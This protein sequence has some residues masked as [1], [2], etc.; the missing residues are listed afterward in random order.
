M[1]PA[2][3]SGGPDPSPQWLRLGGEILAILLPEAGATLG[4]EL[5]FGT[6]SI[7]RPLSQLPLPDR[8]SLLLARDLGDGDLFLRQGEAAFQKLGP[9]QSA[10]HL[11]PLLAAPRLLALLA[12]KAA[13]PLRAAS[14]PA[15]ARDLIA[16]VAQLA[17]PAPEATRPV[18]LLGQGRALWRLEAGGWLLTPQGLLR[19]PDPEGG[20]SPLPA[21]AAGALL[22]RSEGPP[23]RLPPAPP[24]PPTL[25]EIAR[26]EAGS[27]RG[28]LQQSLM[29]LRRHTQEP[30]C[31]DTIRDAQ[32]LAMA[33]TR[34]AA[35]PANAV[36]AAVDRALS[37]HA[38]GVFLI[39]WLHDPLRLTR[40][41]TLR[42]PFGGTLL[43]A[44][45][46]FRV[47]RPD[48][49]KR[50]EQAPFGG[51]DPRPG[52]VVH[53]PSAGPGP[54]A[55]WRVELALGSGEAI[56]LVA[57]P[58]LI[59]PAQ[60]REAVLRGVSPLDVG[61]DLLDR[62]LTPAAERLHRAASAEA[63][64]IDVVHIGTPVA[65]P[66][67]SLV[68]PLYRNLRF[69]KHQLAAFARDPA[70]RGCEIIYVLDSPEQRGEA[71]HLLR[72]VCGLT[73]MAVTLVLHGRNAGYATACNSGAAQATAPFL[74]MLNSDVV[75]D[76]PGWLAPMLA[77]LD[78][79]RRIGCVGPK[80]MFD[81]GSLQHAGL[82][83]ARGPGDD[84]YNSH[85][86]KGFPRHYPEACRAREVPGVTGAAMLM[87]R[88]AWDEVG[89]FSA[90]YIVGDYEDSDLCLRLRQA[91]FTLFYEPAAELFH[92]ERQSIAQ[93]GGYAGTVAAA[94]NRR[95]H[96]RRW[97]SSIAQLM[98][99]FPRIGETFAAA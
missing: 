24:A 59:P 32:V 30:W 94:Y 13:G 80:L 31:R 3:T 46:L 1:G 87:R 29:A 44:E 19:A 16:L 60:A 77:R 4:T 88:A 66:T 92:F 40:G 15:F 48:V 65:A 21:Q 9:A 55:Q 52:F 86:F 90:D 5:R 96:H 26:R 35:E 10:G 54:V 47:S 62:C 42:G 71:D 97:A 67:V 73:G 49:V 23:L 72:G 11:L 39:G 34:A 85:Y 84:W 79:D 56:E 89:G 91:G 51:P 38:G 74:L 63:L 8:G 33:P 45:S 22:L 53:L 99:D 76:R 37:D 82:Y 69:V 14:D 98:A 2:L 81:D 28:L 75:P 41:M 70:L 17:Q 7:F 20:L 61:P 36:A 25:V 64:E 27:R 83:F 78:A 12:S 95:L 18:A 50:F 93:H 68:I 43:P 57:G 58:A 6:G